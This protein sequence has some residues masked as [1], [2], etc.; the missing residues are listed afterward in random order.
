LIKSGTELIRYFGSSSSVVI[1]DEI[2][3]LAYRSFS[4]IQ[5]LGEV[6]LGRDSRLRRVELQAFA[7]TRFTRCDFPKTLEFLDPSAFEG[8]ATPIFSIDPQNPWLRLEDSS[9]CDFGETRFLAFLDP[10][11]PICVPDSV[12]ILACSCFHTGES[13]PPIQFGPGTK[14]RQIQCYGQMG[15]YEESTLESLV[16][17]STLD[18]IDPSA[19]HQCSFYSMSI[20]PANSFYRL[21]G[22]YLCTADR[23]CLVR[24]IGSQSI[25]RVPRSISVIGPYAFSYN[26]WISIVVFDSGSALHS[27]GECAFLSSS[28]SSIILPRSASLIVGS[29]FSHC[30]INDAGVEPGNDHFKIDGPFLLDRNE[31]R[32]VKCLGHSCDAVIPTRIVEIGPFAFCG[33]R[34]RRVRFEDGSQLKRIG[35]FAFQKTL[36]GGIELPQHLEIISA[37]GIREVVSSI[38]PNNPY[39]RVLGN[40]LLDLDGTRIVQYSGRSSQVCVPKEIL[41]LGPCCFSDSIRLDTLRFETGSRL[42]RIEFRAFDTARLKFIALP[43]S[44]EYVNG[45]AFAGCEL[46]SLTVDPANPYL[47]CEGGFLIH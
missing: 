19:F 45:S 28:L 9:L 16:L 4:D 24:Y 12:E 6:Q 32:I 10:D 13:V 17:P 39:F 33:G 35:Q 27:I 37:G 46:E 38:H 8:V 42:R 5:S 15:E 11:R 1:P 34:V 25:V 20:D 26:R 7:C 43:A 23:S 41:I 30:V 18:S 36:L 40:F 2:T 44:V 47:E 14:L 22:A 29:A 21:D 31:K 3:I